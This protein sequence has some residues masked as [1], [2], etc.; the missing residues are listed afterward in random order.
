MDLKEQYEKLLRYC[1]MKTK[2]RFLA[3]DIVQETFLRF[4]QSHS[5]EDTGKEMAYL[6]TIA[7]HLCV[8][9]FRTKEYVNIEDCEE[10]LTNKTAEQ[11]RMLTQIVI[12]H[13]LKK[14]PEDMREIVTLRYVSELSVADIGKILGLSRFAVHRRLKSGLALLKAEL[15]GE[16]DER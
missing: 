2:D 16:K 15:E 14:L 10:V 11:D 7:R 1:Y 8:D 9:A 13:A 6:Y 3:E 12:E 5:Y 4:W